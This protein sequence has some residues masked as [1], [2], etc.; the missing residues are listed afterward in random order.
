MSI[1]HDLCV[2]WFLIEQFRPYAKSARTHPK[3][4]VSQIALS[5]NTNGF[6]NP[7]LVDENFEIIAGHGRLEAA[8]LLGMPEAPAI[9]LKGLTSNQKKAL[10]LADN[11]IAENAGW[12]LEILADQLGSLVGSEIEVDISATG[13]EIAEIDLLVG[14]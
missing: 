11:K 13:F 4:Q 10:R 8:K 9:V 6:V 14:V 5:I 1:I 12:D 3:N 2:N 7:I